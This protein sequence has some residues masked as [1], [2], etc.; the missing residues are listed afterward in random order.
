M[1]MREALQARFGDA[2]E[3]PDAA[4][5]LG[6]MA[7][8]GVCR[9]Y[10]PDPVEPALI[11]TLCAVALSSPT[12]SDLQQRDIVIV[13]DPGVRGRLDAI[14]GFDWQPA[15]PVLLVFC[16]NHA[17]Q[18][19]CHELAGVPFANDHL[20]GFFNA[21][22][23][24]GIA[25][26][27]FV[28]AAERIGLGCCPLSVIRDRAAEVSDLLGLPDRVIP[29][30]GLTSRLAGAAA[31]DRPAAFAGSDRAREPLRRRPGRAHKRIRP[32][33]GRTAALCAPARPRPLGRED[34]LWLVGRQGAP[35][36][37]AA[38][39]G[40]GRIRALEGVLARLTAAG[41]V[42]ARRPADT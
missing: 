21:A 20:D 33:A 24:A 36:C 38:A 29:V 23:D 30:A 5:G 1:S 13:T 8:R 40:L 9:L 19:L 39:G 11:R 4:E 25:L 18:R 32:Q 2:P 35:I 34:G 22:V 27:T 14:T 37:R 26:A 7:A 3:V 42:Q 12:K 15:A 17:R 41:P 10:R 16:A 31:A 6:D 28:T